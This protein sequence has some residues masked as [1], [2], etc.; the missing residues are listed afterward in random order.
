MILSP[1]RSRVN[2]AEPPRARRLAYRLDQPTI[3]RGV[4]DYVDALAVDDV[5]Q[6]AE[7]VARL[8]GLG[9]SLIVAHDAAG[10]MA[11]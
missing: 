3:L 8:R 5:E 9:L 1:G 2:P 4:G 7:A 10:E 6:Q 11:R